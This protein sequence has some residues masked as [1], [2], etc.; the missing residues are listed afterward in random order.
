M[1]NGDVRSFGRED[2]SLQD[3]L[4]Q[5]QPRTLERSLTKE[6]RVYEAAAVAGGLSTLVILAFIGFFLFARSSLVFSEVG[7]GF[8]TS[9]SWRPDASPP[10][11]GI[12]A[13]LYW[14]VIISIIAL[15]IAMPIS[16]LTALFLV[17]YSPRGLRAPLRTL[18]DL[19]AAIPSLIYGL[20]GLFFLQPHLVGISRWL[21]DHASFIP[22]FRVTEPTFT[23]SAFIVSVVLALMIL[24]IITSIV[25]EVLEQTPP[26]EKEAA[27]A[28]GS[29]RSGMVRSVMLPFARGGIIGG[30]ML[31]LGR[32]LGET[33]AVAI[34]LSPS[35]VISPRILETGTN[36]IASLIALKFGEA[37]ELSL[38]ALMAAGL[39]LFALTLTV[40]FIA[41]FVVARSR[42]G[43]GVDA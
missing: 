39:T 7:W 3:Q 26:G 19:L 36:S 37:D 32:A 12:V 15:A 30:S 5:D 41:S 8:F 10:E 4:P 14:T 16:I 43:A 2:G 6:D 21:S 24:P 25:R 20:W 35:L 33:I 29:T 34:I 1:Q 18:V 23:G 17:E 27:L 13:I 22:L 9:L 38:S 40:N 31:G 28:L 11:F 42:S